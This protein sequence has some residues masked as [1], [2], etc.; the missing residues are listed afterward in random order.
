VLWTRRLDKLVSLGSNGEDILR[1]SDH[2]GGE[3]RDDHNLDKE[4]IG[5]G[6]VR[7]THMYTQI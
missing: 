2:W 4:E 5:K 1:E 6:K 7:L 3:N